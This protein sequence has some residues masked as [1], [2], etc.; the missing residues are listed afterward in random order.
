[1]SDI[2]S[3]CYLDPESVQEALRDIVYHNTMADQRYHGDP[4]WTF[5]N[6]YIVEG[7]TVCQTKD[8]SGSSNIDKGITQ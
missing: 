3:F 5:S 1:M 6:E 4:S 2:F 8:V 7:K